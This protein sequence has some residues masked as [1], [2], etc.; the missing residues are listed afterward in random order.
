MNEG[1]LPTR[2]SEPAN[3]RSGGGG[4]QVSV[5]LGAWKTQG[6]AVDELP[7]EPYRFHNEHHRHDYELVHGQPIQKMTPT[8]VERWEVA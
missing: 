1:Q 6:R 7:L 3:V 5:I 8:E 2:P 4:R